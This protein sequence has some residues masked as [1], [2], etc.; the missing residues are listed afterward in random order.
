MIAA[1]GMGREVLPSPDT[2]PTFDLSV[3]MVAMV[4]HLILSVIYSLI[5]AFI[6]QRMDMGSAVV[7]GA[8]FGLAL[9]LVN[10]Y[11]FTAVFPWFANARTWITLFTHIVFGA[12]A[13]ALYKALEKPEAR[14][15]YTG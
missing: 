9:Y 14:K 13:A 10:F 8:V 6:V 1:I 2:P 3:L 4:L 7:V 11:V 15:A 12:V 5:Q